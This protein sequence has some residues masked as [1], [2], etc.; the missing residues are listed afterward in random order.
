MAGYKMAAGHTCAALLLLVK[1][2]SDVAGA[3]DFATQIERSG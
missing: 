3:I 2:V 1:P